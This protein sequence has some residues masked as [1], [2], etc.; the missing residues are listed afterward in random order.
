MKNFEKKQR[1]ETIIMRSFAALAPGLIAIAVY[2]WLMEDNYVDVVALI[3]ALLFALL[4]IIT[5][6]LREKRFEK[7]KTK[8]KRLEP[9]EEIETLIEGI[10]RV[11]FY[12]DDDNGVIIVNLNEDYEVTKISMSTYEINKNFKSS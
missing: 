12:K 11:E 2:S 3:A 1:V 7:I 4:L 5:I 8:Y 6:W 9:S 10:A